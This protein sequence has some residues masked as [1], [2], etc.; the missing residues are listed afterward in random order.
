[1][2]CVVRGGGG[3]A[4]FGLVTAV[5]SWGVACDFSSVLGRGFGEVRKEVFEDDV[6]VC[7]GWVCIV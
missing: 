2:L 1:M 4:R 7:G 5:F 3:G 6:I